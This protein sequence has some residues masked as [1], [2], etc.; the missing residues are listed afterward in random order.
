M[1]RVYLLRQQNTTR[2]YSE[3]LGDRHC[4]Y[5]FRN[6]MH[7][8]KC[9]NFLHEYKNRYR[10]YPG[11]EQKKCTL[12]SK[13]EPVYIESGHVEDM[14]VTCVLNGMHLFEVHDFDYERE[15]VRLTG[16]LLTEGIEVFP[17][18]TRTHLE[19]ILDL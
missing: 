2:Y 18:H 9:K 13:T 5:G 11:V 8:V 19:Y 15:E 16:V 4:I 12:V 1:S 3:I 10:V 17:D 14:K 7:A 6:R